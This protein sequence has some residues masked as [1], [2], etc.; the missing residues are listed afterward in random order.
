[1]NNV[2]DLIQKSYLI[3]SLIASDFFW[4]MNKKKEFM[5]ILK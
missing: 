1:M 3:R 4:V 5:N 2:P